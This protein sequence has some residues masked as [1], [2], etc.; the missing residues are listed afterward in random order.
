MPMLTS[1]DRITRARAL[2]E[3]KGQPTND[4]LNSEIQDSWGRCIDHGLDPLSMPEHVMVDTCD[5]H[6]LRDS[7]D[8]LLI[9]AKSEVQN[10]YSQISGSNFAIVFASHDGTIIES[11]CDDSFD[12]FADAKRI[13]PGSLWRETV[14]GTNALGSVVH[15][16]RPCTV[17]AGEHFFRCY[18]DLTCVASP[19]FDPM[20]KL[21][22]IIDASSNCRTRQ[23]H[24]HALVKMSCITIENG[25]FR[26]AFRDQLIIELHSRQEFLGTLQAGLLAFCDDGKLISANQQAR[27]LLQ[28]ISLHSGTH[29]D[30]I[31]QTSL[32]AF[33]SRRSSALPASL[34]DLRGSTYAVEAAYPFEPVFAR[35]RSIASPAHFRPSI[36][37]QPRMVCDDPDVRALVEQVERATHIKAPIHIRG[38]TGTGKEMLARHVH[39][40]SGRSGSFVPVNCAALPDTLAEAE[41]FGYRGGAF[42]GAVRGGSPG[43]ALQADKGTLFLDEIG[44]MPVALQATL[45]RFL[46]GWRVRAVGGTTEKQVDIQLVTATNR[47]LDI[48]VHNKQFR[49]DLLYRINT[50]DIELR[51][52][53][54]RTDIDKIISAL[55]ESLGLKMSIDQD[56]IASLHDYWWPGNI[57]ELKNFL[58]RISIDAHDGPISLDHINHALRAARKTSAADAPLQGASLEEHECCVVQETYKQLNGNVSAV[59]RKLGISRNTVY[60]KLKIDEA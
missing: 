6:E 16:G 19:I 14:S 28:G 17:H 29:F 21:V 36:E 58:V 38:E 9:L 52:L 59:A 18:E 33:R 30:V 31:F 8:D 32:S 39:E 4:F 25:Q 35:N 5:L 43:L 40:V 46:D 15:A 55:I 60:K 3:R 24:T 44:E 22:G 45:L 27:Y 37:S 23:H 26:R 48:A 54:H 13:T 7:F 2:L 47:D 12:S 49:A 56:A 10:L 11:I 20:G 57:R 50:I 42:T 41:L 34:T 53:R 1:D 51:P